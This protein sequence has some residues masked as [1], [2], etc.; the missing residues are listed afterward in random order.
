M[1]GL[2]SMLRADPFIMKYIFYLF[3]SLQVAYGF[4]DLYLLRRVDHYWATSQNIVKDGQLLSESRTLEMFD[5]WYTLSN[6]VLMA[7][8][9]LIII[10]ALLFMLFA[11]FKALK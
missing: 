8:G 4:F 10:F 6:A 9:L 1:T 2:L 3:V 5:A 7:N 11:T